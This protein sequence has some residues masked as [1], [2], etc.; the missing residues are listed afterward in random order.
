MLN[1]LAQKEILSDIQISEGLRVCFVCTGNTCRSPM[2]AALFNHYLKSKGR[3]ADSAG[4]HASQGAAMSKHAKTALKEAGIDVVAHSAK[5]IT[6]KIIADF[7]RVVCMTAGHALALISAYPQHAGKITAL[8]Q[9]ISDPF[10]GDI[11]EYK[12]C[13]KQIKAA[14]IEEFPAFAIEV[15]RAE[16]ADD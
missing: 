11:Q 13:L 4:T 12:E 8:V 5:R 1:N 2:A 16:K 15:Q 9:D 10:G 3:H 6:E 14:L 7:D